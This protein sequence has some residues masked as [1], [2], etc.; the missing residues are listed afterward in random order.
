VADIDYHGENIYLSELKKNFS[1]KK[2][3]E[4][5]PLI[6][7]V[8]LHAYQLGFEGLNGEQIQGVAEYPK[9]FGALV[10]QL[11]KFSNKK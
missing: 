8:A 5:E 10:K 11:R 3:T 9:D 1:L 4:E 6:K 7:R 2:H